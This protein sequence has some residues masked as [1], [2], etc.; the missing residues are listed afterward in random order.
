MDRTKLL[1]KIQALIK[2]QDAANNL[3][4]LNLLRS[5]SE[6]TFLEA[7]RLLQ[8]VPTDSD[9]SLGGSRYILPIGSYTIVFL[10]WHK[11]NSSLG[12]PYLFIHRQ[13]TI[14]QQLLPSYH[15]DFSIH[16]FESENEREMYEAMIDLPNL[17]EGLESLLL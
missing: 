5:Q 12:Y 14:E 8:F 4:A 15:K 6:T 17:G 16:F 10:M 3:L 13:V 2:T 1:K 11:W 9:D 7:F